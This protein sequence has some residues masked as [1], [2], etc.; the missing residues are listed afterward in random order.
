MPKKTK[1]I[2]YMKDSCPNLS[3][4]AE[5]GFDCLSIDWKVSLTG[6]WQELNTNK[7]NTIKCLQGNLD[8]EIL[9]LVPSNKNQEELITSLITKKTGEIITEGKALNCGHIMNLGHGIYPNTLVENA[10]KFIEIVKSK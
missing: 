4:I 10:Q 1:K 2:L 8:P 7:K 5:L 3:E 9:T 6:A